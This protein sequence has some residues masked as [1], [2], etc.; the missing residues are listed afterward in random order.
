MSMQQTNV[1]KSLLD[2]N[3]QGKP[4]PRSQSRKVSELSRTRYEVQRTKT[5][6]PKSGYITYASNCY[7]DSAIKYL[8]KA[9]KEFPESA[10]YKHRVIEI[11]TMEII[12][13]Q[14]TKVRKL[15]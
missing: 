13:E 1:Q 5:K 7:Y 9:K 10:G 15:K 6:H 14:V 2:S 4:A 11:T 3:N 12:V 8:E